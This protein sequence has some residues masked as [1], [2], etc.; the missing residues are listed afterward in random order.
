MEVKAIDHSRK[1]I[2]HSPQSPGYTCWV[3]SSVMPDGCV[4]VGFTQATGPREG[5]PKAP[6]DVRRRLAWPPSCIK[7]R[8]LREAY[9]MT[10]LD[11][12]NVYLR[13]TDGGKTWE[14]AGLDPFK[15]CM[16][17]M[18]GCHATLSD[19]TVV[20]GVW[21]HYLPYDPEA[22]KTGYIQRSTDG[23]KTWG[24]P[25]LILDP[26]RYTAWPRRV[27][28][29]RDGR[30]IVFGGLARV[31]ADSRTRG[32]YSALIDPALQVSSD[33]GR[34]WSAPIDVVPKEY[35]GK[36]GGEEFD[37]AELANG[38]LLCVF[39][40]RRYDESKG[41]FVS[42]EERWQGVLRKQGDS[43][44]PADVGPAPFPHSGYPE[45]LATREG[46]VLHLATS[47]VHWTADAGKSWR[48]LNVPGTGYY[49]SAVQTPDGWI[50]VFWHHGS[51]NAY[52][53]VD[54]YVGMD[55]FKL[56]VTAE[57]PP[58]DDAT[59]RE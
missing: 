3:S 55:R 35:Q 18:S 2:Y 44:A 46:V 14:Q 51:D 23:A 43:W 17:G 42:G 1:Q 11:M 13:S 27:C 49:P 52:G 38:D 41:R 6:E 5:R 4:L 40:K 28:V 59:G 56:E 20:R 54:Q 33:G 26:E 25:E 58:G 48:R 53:E 7:D 32:G 50:A 29:L 30:L 47:G 15:S 57:A 22:P 36:W 45:L 19:G 34:T 9:D 16:N 31:P 8:E 24:K 21:G 37:V 10:G 12:A 39:R